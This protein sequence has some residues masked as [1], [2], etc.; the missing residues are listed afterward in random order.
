MLLQKCPY[1]LKI[2]KLPHMSKCMSFKMGF[3]SFKQ[4]ELFYD[5][6]NHLESIES[7]ELREYPI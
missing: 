2:A 5:N 3:G 1:L 6:N 4:L 7:D